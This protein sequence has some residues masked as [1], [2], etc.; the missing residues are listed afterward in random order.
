MII[1][2]GETHTLGAAKYL[3]VFS[4]NRAFSIS[5]KDEGLA[6][7][8]VKAGFSYDLEGYRLITFHNDGIDDLDTDFEMST[9][10]VVTGSNAG[11]EILNTPT[12]QRIIEPIA[13]TAEATV[14]NGT[15]HLIAAGS[16]ADIVDITINANSAKDILVANADRKSALIQVISATKTPVR[17]GGATVASGRG[18]YASGS[19][20]N[21][22]II[23]I[24]VKGLI[25]IYNDSNEQATI[26]AV[27]LLT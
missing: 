8:T 26:S 7:T 5:S 17:I 23:P 10:R 20:A 22:A 13:V 12:I 18:I 6:K 21:P 27:E 19:L 2:A 4:S 25:R 16:L 9:L 15:M 24:S 3:N 14:E 11:V 1:K